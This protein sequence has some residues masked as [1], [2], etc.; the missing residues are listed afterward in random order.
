MPRACSRTLDTA[1]PHNRKFPADGPYGI[2]LWS[3][4]SSNRARRSRSAA[5]RDRSAR[6]RAH[7]HVHGHRRALERADVA[8]S[9]RRAQPGAARARGAHRGDRGAAR[10]RRRLQRDSVFAVLRRVARG[11]GAHGF[12]A[13]PYA[14]RQLADDAAHRGHPHRPCHGERRLYDS[15]AP[16]PPELRVRPLRRARRARIAAAR[17]SH[18]RAT[19][20]LRAHH[21]QRDLVRQNAG[22]EPAIPRL[23]AREARHS[24]RRRPRRARRAR[25]DHPASQRSAPRVHVRVHDGRHRP[26]ARRHHGRVRRAG[27]RRSARAQRR[28][29]RS[30]CSAA[31]GRSTKRG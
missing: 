26:D 30:A 4:S 19:D 24:A 21:R 14:Q 10:R 11:D 22:H 9:R 3:R 18:E 12:A 27:I 16:P 6:A 5:A 25:G 23:R 13:R 8:A 31:A 7:E 28:G 20:G 1:F 15:L 2:G 17:S 29:R